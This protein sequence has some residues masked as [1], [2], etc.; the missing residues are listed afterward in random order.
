MKTPNP[1]RF[2]GNILLA[3]AAAAAA[4]LLGATVSASSGSSSD[5]PT[6]DRCVS[7]ADAAA[8]WLENGGTLPRCANE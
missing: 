5:D 4:A 8:G 1:R 2:G 7:T 6:I 3:F